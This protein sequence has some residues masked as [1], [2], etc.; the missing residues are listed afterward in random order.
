[1]AINFNVN[2]YYDDYNEDKG[3]HRILFK[4][5]V[6]VQARELT[7]LQ[8]ILQKQVERM[9]KHFFED[10]AMVI[11]GQIAI[12]TRVKA[13]KLTAASVGTRSVANDFTS[14]NLVVSGSTT[15]VEA[16]VLLGVDA[17]G[18]DPPTLLVRFTKTGTNNIDREFTTSETIIATISGQPISFITASST[19][20]VESSMAFIDAGV[21]FVAQTF[22]KVLA[23]RIYLEKYTT[24][25]SYRVGL[26]LSESIITSDDD[27]SLTDNAL[28]SPNEAAPG[29]DRYKISL[30]LSKLSLTSTLDQDFIELARVVNGVVT[31]SVSRTKYSVLEKTLARRTFEES[32]NYTVNP[33]RLQLREY[34]NNFRGE[35]TSGANVLVGDIAT[36]NGNTYVATTAGLTGGSAPTHTFGEA[37]SG[38]TW[39]YTQFPKYNSGLFS[40]KNNSTLTTEQ[41]GE[42][43]FVA[44]VEP[45]K[46]YISGY[47]VEKIATDYI[48]IPKS[49]EY[50]SV[51]SDDISTTIGNYVVVS[52]VYLNVTSVNVESS[53]TVDLYNQFGP[54]TKVGTAKIR[55]INYDSGNASLTNA[56]FRLSLFDIDLNEGKSFSRDVKHFNTTGF[57]ANIQGFNSDYVVLTGTGNASAST[58]VNGSG[59]LFTDE[60]V[61]GDYIYFDSPAEGTRR[62][63]AVN[64]D[65]SITIDS[66]ATITNSRLYRVQAQLKN[67]EFTPAIFLMPFSGIKSVVP[68]V[69]ITA[70]TLTGSSDGSGVLTLTLGS[71]TFPAGTS[72][73]SVVVFNRTSGRTQKPTFT[74]LTADNSSL[75]ITGLTASNNYSVVAPQKQTLTAPDY[76]KKTKTP[77]FASITVTDPKIYSSREIDLGKTDVFEIVGITQETSNGNVEI[78]DWFVLDNGQRSTY[79]DVSKLV[80]RTNYPAP[81]GNIR[82]GFRYFSHSAGIY[83]SKDSYINILYENIPVFYGDNYSVRLADVLDFRPVKNDNGVGFKTQYLPHTGFDNYFSYDYYLTR[84]DKVCVDL[85]GNV[86]TLQGAAALISQDPNDPAVGMP[87]YKLNLQPY[88][89]STKEPDIRVDIVDNKRFTMKD[90]ANLEKRIENIE[91]YTALSLL[92]QDTVSLSIRDAYGLERFKNG[93]VVDNFEG[94]GVGDVFAP[95]YRCSVDM[96]NNELRPQYTIDNVN[97]VEKNITEADRTSAGYQVTGD[98]VTL[99]YSSVALVDQPYASRVENVNPFSVAT[100]LGDIQ[101]TPSSD[102]WFE[103]ETRPE[104][105]VNEEG[106]FDAVVTTLESAGALTTV[107]NAWQTQWSGT[108][109]SSV[110]R[111]DSQLGSTLGTDFDR[112]FGITNAGAQVAGAS[113]QVNLQVDTITSGQARSGVRTSVVSRIDRRVI[114]D[115]VVSTATIPFIRSRALRFVGRG[116]KPNTRLYAFFDNVNVGAYIRPATKLTYSAVSGTF[117][118]Q[119]NYDTYGDENDRNPRRISSVSEPAFNKGDIVYEGTT[120]ATANATGVVAYVD[121]Q[122]TPKVLHVVN[123]K[124]TFVAGRTITGSPS[125]STT[126]TVSANATI[127]TTGNA[128]ITNAYGDIAGVFTIP[129]SAALRFRTG[130]REF[131]L[132]DDISNI[133]GNTTSS[134]RVIYP[135]TGVLQTRQSTIAA[136]RNAEIVRNQVSDTRTITESLERVVSDTGWNAPP[137]PP[138]VLPPQPAVV[139]SEPTPAAAGDMWWGTDNVGGDGGPGGGEDPLAQTFTVD[140]RGGCFLTKIDIFFSQ[141]DSTLPIT[142]EIRTTVNGYP[143]SRVLPF[144]RV[145]LTPAQ[146]NTSADANTPTTFTFP[147]P[148]YVQEGVEYAIVLLSDSFNYKVWISQLGDDLVG[149]DRKISQQPYLGSL[150]KS[151]NASTW[152]ADQLQ[153]LKFKLYRA[154][155]DTANIGKLSLVNESLSPKLLPKNAIILSNTSPHV[156]VVHPSHGMSSGASVTLS[157]FTDTGNVK[158]SDINKT[159]TIANVLLDSYTVL[160]GNIANVTTTFTTANI[161]A[162]EDIVFDVMQPIIQFQNFPQ[163]T[164]SFTANVST[165]SLGST[166]SSTPVSVVANENNYFASPRAIKSTV[167]EVGSGTGRKAF[168]LVCFMASVQNNLSPIIDLNRT[169]LV[170]ISNRINDITANTAN[171]VHHNT[172]VLSAN[173]KIEFSGNTLATTSGDVANILAQ[174]VPG[175]TITITN[176]GGNAT[177]NANVVISSVKNL[178]GVANVTCYYTFATELSGN[179]Y[180]IVQKE[181]FVDER[182]PQNGSA[183]AKYITRQLNF[184]NPSRYLR[185]MFAANAP[186]GTAIDVYYRTLVLGSLIPLKDTN[187]VQATPVTPIVPTNDPSQFTDITYEIDNL[188]AFSAAAVKIVFRSSNSSQI[189][190]IKDLRIVACP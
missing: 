150:F 8:T 143:G 56:T 30:T 180:T 108:S 147:S 181:N 105:V 171:F 89:M 183:A 88:T 39:L 78:S 81:S 166:R 117:D 127:E 24:T 28:G 146:V 49:R 93:F 69:I 133:S 134:G 65:Y 186:A 40:P 50:S 103:V 84:K 160:S 145:V 53:T 122:S 174:L 11:P 23:Q 177:N 136:T 172:T 140:Q 107:W 6:S 64:S 46:A 190:S 164:V 184:Q 104:I 157:G 188:P 75:T 66:A 85:N 35:W 113:R 83:F 27:S 178:N 21:Y 32:G 167:N 169:S 16:I 156:T 17:E 38:V 102:E 19:P 86:F 138:A 111:L 129:N 110:T 63:T 131:K 120:L 61:V 73:D 3:F 7:Q 68:N 148:V 15:G 76:Q 119:T 98:L 12:D 10:G 48:S 179:A 82:V 22:V 55:A 151:Q 153:D 142:L 124:G 41:A 87:L 158:A 176:V 126:G 96:E 139:F 115:R 185:I 29:A 154:Q 2:P 91:Y 159:H 95:D 161:R 97:L 60:L 118:Y 33:F 18:S 149:T 47:E 100:F 57:S 121:T 187:Y 59:S 77:T 9:G 34:R 114:D 26:T 144:A 25:P 101:L 182:A 92:E 189:P 125:T 165:A 54:T 155:F 123:V 72:T 67:T 162:T 62:V 137:P 79:Y 37:T 36:Y 109:T 52:N 116:F 135:A 31:K 106:N 45:G 132:A 42:A 70:N 13:V 14:G 170:A 112:R 168:E 141:K 58:T 43:L 51:I 128:L 74:T 5:S 4:P 94:H 99:K 90:I 80:R 175:K 44:G 152:N 163:T 20:V 173:T 71:G 130:N 1:M